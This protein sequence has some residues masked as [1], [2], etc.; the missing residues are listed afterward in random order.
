MS[1]RTVPYLPIHLPSSTEQK[2]ESSGQGESAEHLS[3]RKMVNSSVMI[4]RSLPEKCIDVEYINVSTKNVLQQ[5]LLFLSQ[6][7]VVEGQSWSSSH[8]ERKMENQLIYI[9]IY[10]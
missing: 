1:Y 4:S 10:I 7:G 6:L 8:S 3:R 5:V 2:C 9:S